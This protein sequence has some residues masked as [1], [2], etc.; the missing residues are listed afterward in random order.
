MTIC[1][2][3]FIFAEK[4]FK[5]FGAD[6]YRF[7]CL[8]SHPKQWK[9]VAQK[10][11]RH[12]LELFQFHIYALLTIKRLRDVYLYLQKSK[13]EFEA[14]ISDWVI[15]S[16]HY[17]GLRELS[18][19]LICSLYRRHIRTLSDIIVCKGGYP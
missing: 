9:V 16:Y 10:P 5:P 19:D 8:F 17:L 6:P 1:I 3:S 11:M 12:Q 18:K 13:R 15:A 14:V 2:F 4:L 7:S